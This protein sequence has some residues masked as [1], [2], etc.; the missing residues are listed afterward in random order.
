MRINLVE[1]PLSKDQEGSAVP[2]LF[3][4]CYALAET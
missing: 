2:I 4:E 1:P 3:E